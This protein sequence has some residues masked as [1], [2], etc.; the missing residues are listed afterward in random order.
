MKTNFRKMQ[1]STNWIT[2]VLL[3]L[4]IATYG[5]FAQTHASERGIGFDEQ[6]PFPSVH[7][8]EDEITTRNQGIPTLNC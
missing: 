3:T 2:T 1:P 6:L 4:I 8:C 5:I 7:L